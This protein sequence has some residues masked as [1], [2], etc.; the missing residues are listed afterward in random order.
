MYV[1]FLISLFLTLAR[2]T[3][4]TSSSVIRVKI[5][6]VQFLNLLYCF[7]SEIHFKGKSEGNRSASL[8]Q[9]IDFERKQNRASRLWLCWGKLKK[10]LC[11]DPRPPRVWKNW[12]GLVRV[13]WELL[14]GTMPRIYPRP[15]KLELLGV[16]PRHWCTLKLPQ[17]SLWLAGTKNHWH[18]PHLHP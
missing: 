9:T 14:N 16:G 3:D 6:N 17:V 15:I 8:C 10:H 13:T 11:P 18:S 5:I 12:S 7:I 4:S 2:D 1:I